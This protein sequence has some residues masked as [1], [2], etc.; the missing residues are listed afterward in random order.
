MPD[1]KQI[2]KALDYAIEHS[3]VDLKKLSPE[4]RTLIDDTR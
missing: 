1:N 2:D 3:P 4:G